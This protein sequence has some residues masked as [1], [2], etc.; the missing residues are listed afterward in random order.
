VPHPT[1]S[2][3]QPP[4]EGSETAP[5]ETVAAATEADG[6]EAASA[7]T[8]ASTG[9]QDG[10]AKPA[11]RSWDPL[12]TGADLPGWQTRSRE[13]WSVQGKPPAASLRLLGDASDGARSATV[14]V[15]ERSYRNL[16]Y[17]LRARPETAGTAFG[18][19]V[20]AQREQTV[21][22]EF[23]GARGTLRVDDRVEPVSFE[24]QAGTWHQVAVIAANRDVLVYIDKRKVAAM[25]DVSL[26][27]AG[28]I[29]VYCTDGAVELQTMYMQVLD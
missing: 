24:W 25:S 12:L 4:E 21:R 22:L 23:V 10:A 8:T 6:S 14:L 28:R 27:T 18:L 1:L 13:G 17:T 5:A 2:P 11:R 20:R 9:T 15:T 19:L 29:G 7:G 3:P 16:A 26:E